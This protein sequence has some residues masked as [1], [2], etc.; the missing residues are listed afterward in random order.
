VLSGL[1]VVSMLVP[2]LPRQ[3]FADPLP[4]DQG[5]IPQGMSR[6]EY[7]ACQT[8]DEASFR[9]AIE[10][11][12]T[13]SLERSLASVDFKALVTDEWREGGLD[14]IIDTRVDIAVAEVRDETSWGTLISSLASKE[15]AQE[16][17]VAVAERVYRSDAVK[18]AIESLAN[19]VGNELGKRLEIASV[20]ASEPAIECLKA[21]LGPRYGA[22]VARTVT[23]GAEAG[24]AVS[25]EDA[26]AEI[27]A[28]DKLRQA[29]GGLTGVAILVLRREMANMA[30]RIGQ[31]L[32]GSVL[33][34]LVSVVAGGVGLVLI[35]KDIWDLRHGVLPII[36][37]EMKSAQSKDR[38]RQELADA[39][40]EQIRD[41]VK[42]IAAK[43]A[44][45][46][47]AVWDGFRQAHAKV[48]EIAD[49]DPAFRSY[50]DG[51]AAEKLPRLDEV[52]ALVLSVEGPQGLTRR[53]GD[54]TLD[55]A[56][57]RMSASAFEVARSTRSLETALKW[58]A[59]AGDHS[60][61]VV[62]FELYR[63]AKPEDFTSAS[64]AR[65]L[66]VGDR[67]A[68]T[69]LARVSRPARDTLFDLQAEDLKTLAR[70][71]SEQ[72]LETLAGYLEKLE[73]GPRER[74][75]RAVANNPSAMQLMAPENV[76][77]AV[78]ASR[79]QSAA[80]EM[81]LRPQGVLDPVAAY[82]DMVAAWEGRVSPVLI[83]YKHP[84][85]VA[86]LGVLLLLLLLLLRRLLRPRRPT[87]TEEAVG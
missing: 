35:A 74:V 33:S 83:W 68:I 8:R 3:A 73:K 34:R 60:D 40:A 87:R 44:D 59:I 65:L 66:S 67:L 17:A 57:V 85:A 49:Q 5:L 37:D 76:R 71:L 1:I 6:A 2:G 14:Q 9:K 72:E 18:A 75:L 7:D 13:K 61:A 10:A 26:R 48:L 15:K 20:D 52:V 28:A 16:L 81:M 47:I 70:S 62:E 43:S 54:G 24:F 69:R 32:V 56:V 50:L 30:R 80:V 55:Q 31:R 19:G 79:D 27:S 82:T 4:Q 53:L 38:V 86:A 12:T 46:V 78:I 25:P 84:A 63:R 29:S 39:L 51:L 42:E 41:H 11:I 64:L 21:F 22:S 45:H 23:R 58:S 36:A 77:N